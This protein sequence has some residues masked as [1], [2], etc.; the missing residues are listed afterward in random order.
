MFK[1]IGQVMGM[2]KNLP[3]IQ[4][5]FQKFQESLSKITAEGDAGAGM[6]RVRVNGLHQV[7]RIDLSDELFTSPDKEMME[8]L[9]RAATNQAI[10]KVGELVT[11]ERAKLAEGLGMPGGMNLPGMPGIT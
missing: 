5:E 9:I 8:D 4:E 10:E 11:Q 1:E 7:Q 2:M 6:V 3:K